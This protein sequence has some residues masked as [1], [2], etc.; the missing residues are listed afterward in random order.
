MK[1]LALQNNW[2]LYVDEYGNLAMKEGNGRLAQDVASSVRIFK[3]E[4]GFDTGRGVEYN[5]PDESRQTLNRQMNMQTRYIDGVED[6]VVIF[7]EL[8]NRELKPVVY[9]TNIN[10]EEVIVG[11]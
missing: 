4:D 10:D 7:E 1:T 11:E 8:N 2:D 5:K 6:S 3:G 9:I